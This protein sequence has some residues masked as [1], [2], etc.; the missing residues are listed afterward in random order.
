MLKVVAVLSCSLAC[1]AVA[2]VARLDL[3]VWTGDR[4]S[5]VHEARAGDN[6][7][8]GLFGAFENAYG[9]AGCVVAIEAA[10][11]AAGDAFRGGARALPF[12]FGQFEQAAY[13]SGN[14]L[15]IDAAD[16]ADD[17][18][19][20]GLNLHQAAAMDAAG[21]GRVFSTANPA[22][23]YVFDITLA[24]DATGR[25]I[26][27]DV[28]LAQIKLGVLS[29]YLS[30]QSRDTRRDQ[31]SLTDGATINVIPAPATVLVSGLVGMRR[32]RR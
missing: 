12:D 19:V 3:K 32:R 4:W 8:V 1:A 18:S 20:R 13:V 29:S 10:G 24:A 11:W 28:P 26:V 5:D 21:L 9:F 17:S 15:R 31:A 16:D 23:L 30:A 2:D 27:F 7:R 6:V 14:R 22:L 25:S